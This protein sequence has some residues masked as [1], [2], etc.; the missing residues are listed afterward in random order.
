MSIRE[1]LVKFRQ[2][3][4][5]CINDKDDTDKKIENR[6]DQALSAIK[7]ELKEKIDRL[8]TQGTYQE[9]GTYIIQEL[10]TKSQ[11]LKIIEE[12]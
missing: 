4:W 1:I 11:I 2:A 7:S 12:A 5:I 9:S 8:P 3:E 10:I 6:L